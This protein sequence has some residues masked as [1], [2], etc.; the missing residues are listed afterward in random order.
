[1]DTATMIYELW[2]HTYLQP[3][4]ALDRTQHQSRFCAALESQM[5]QQPLQH[6]AGHT[7]LQHNFTFL[8]LCFNI[9]GV[10]FSPFRPV[11]HTTSPACMRG[12]GMTH[13][14]QCSISLSLSCITAACIN[15]YDAM[16]ESWPMQKTVG[17][18]MNK[19]EVLIEWPTCTTHG[20]EQ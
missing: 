14:I 15:K 18:S 13:A 12:Q 8:K 9:K 4:Q 10:P 2:P 5:L 11:Y 17:R 19:Q 16:A 20:A 7:V 1:M 6:Q 3:P